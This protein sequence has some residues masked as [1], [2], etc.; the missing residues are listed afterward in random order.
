MRKKLSELIL[1]KDPLCEQV[2]ICVDEL[3]GHN[4]CPQAENKNKPLATRFFDWTGTNK[5]RPAERTRIHL[6]LLKSPEIIEGRKGHGGRE[7]QNAH[8]T[9]N[10]CTELVDSSPHKDTIVPHS[11]CITPISGAVK[12]R[13]WPKGLVH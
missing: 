1:S 10:L 12:S 6:C 4:T 2:G 8:G 11:L 3:K 7:Q 13:S 5:G 9:D